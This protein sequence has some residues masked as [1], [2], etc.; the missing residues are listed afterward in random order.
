MA[1]NSLFSPNGL[2]VGNLFNPTDVV[3]ANGDI[4]AGNTVTA[5]YFLGNGAFLTGIPVGN[6][7]VSN[8]APVSAQQ[9]DV[10]IQAN[11]GTQYIYFTSS[12]NSQWA[13]MEAAISISS[14]T[15]AN[16]DLTA[17]SSNIIPTANITYDIG[18]TSNRFRDIYLANSTIYLGDAEI[19]A[20][21]SNVVI[22][23]A[24]IASA[25]VGNMNNDSTG[26]MSLPVGNTAQRPVAPT[27]G[28]IRFNTTTN[29]P[30]W[31][32]PIG[33]QWLNLSQGP[34]YN[35]EYLVIAGGGGGGA[36]RGGGGGAGGY[37]TDTG[38]S[39]SV[40][41]SYTVTVGAGGTAGIPSAQ[42]TSGG[43]SVFSSITS[44]GGGAGGTGFV[45]SNNNGLSG[46]S[47]G[48]GA[49][50]SAPTGGTGGS[51]T[52]GQGFAGA[53]SQT[54]GEGYSGG[55]GGGASA[56]G[57][58]GSVGNAPAGNGGSGTASSI[59][60]T[61]VTYAGGGGGGNYSAA[62]SPARVGGTGGSGGGGNGGAWGDGPG[63]QV[64]ATAGTTNRG[65]GGG[66]GGNSQGGAAGGSGI[67]IIRYLGAQ[68]GSGGTV[69]S[70][71]GYTIH[72]FNSSGTY[73]A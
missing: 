24:V 60:G 64:S 17:V 45:S 62:P 44:I 28:M 70:S 40:G 65:S 34:N 47:G 4:T 68:R 71:G 61:S 66:G 1:L 50:L 25:T 9:G 6:T 15:G 49:A 37:L 69:T 46:G 63:V 33:N 36:G 8:T 31:Y 29:S 39:V 51:A 12:G 41:T 3:W 59:T 54:G 52:P 22:A 19:S 11:T 58:T 2:S 42:G 43:N 26:Y 56:A 27:A 21:G 55:G 30:E 38:I 48:G 18:N 32:D 13:E 73:T 35:V 72:T 16:I 20:N 14:S 23:S 67:V 10:W 53:S 7:T 5:N 57:T